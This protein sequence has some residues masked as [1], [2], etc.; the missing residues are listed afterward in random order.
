M[1][2]HQESHHF[3][4]SKLTKGTSSITPSELLLVLDCL[5]GRVNLPKMTFLSPRDA[6]SVK[7]PPRNSS[8]SRFWGL[9]RRPHDRTVTEKHYQQ[10]ATEPI[11]GAAIEIATLVNLRPTTIYSTFQVKNA[12]MPRV[13]HKD[14]KRPTP[15]ASCMSCMS[16][17]LGDFNVQMHVIVSWYIQ[18]FGNLG[19]L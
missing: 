4:E 13:G 5:K 12:T 15:N 8:K 3:L 6:V 19:V 16:Y 1:G 9:A 14:L 10:S 2:N 11:Q 18:Q 7:S 17:H